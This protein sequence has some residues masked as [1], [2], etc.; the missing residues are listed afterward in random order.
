MVGK[1]IVTEV[2]EFIKDNPYCNKSDVERGVKVCTRLPIREAIEIL[3]SDRDGTVEP[4]VKFSKNTPNGFYHLYVN[5]KNEYNVLEKRISQLYQMAEELDEQVKMIKLSPDYPSM[6]NKGGQNGKF[7]L[8]IG[9][10]IHTT[11]MIRYSKI[12]QLAN[13]IQQKIKSNEERET[14]YLQLV[15]VLALTSK[16]NKSTMLPFVVEGFLTTVEGLNLNKELTTGLKSIVNSWIFGTQ[17]A[18]QSRN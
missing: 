13:E 2:Y 3:T 6:K 9:N 14:L 17:D 1:E 5:D 10:L 18:Q 8:Q 7:N 16:S 11:Q 4:K 12:A 15:R